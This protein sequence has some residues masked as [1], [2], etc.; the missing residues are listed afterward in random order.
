MITT[1]LIRYFSEEKYADAF[2]KNG[3]VLFRTLSFFKNH[4]DNEIR[5]DQNEGTLV[6]R[7]MSG[8]QVTKV[9]TG[10]VITLPHS[11]ESTVKTDEIF[12]Y[13]MSTELST[14][15]AE[16]FTAVVA[17]EIVDPLKFLARLRNSLSLR[18][19]LR[20]CKLI[21]EAI[22]YY[23]VDEPP[24]VDW[25]LPDRITMRKSKFFGWQKEYRFVVP[26][27]DAFRIENVNIKL[28]MP[29]TKSASNPSSHPPLCL[30]LGNLKSICRVHRF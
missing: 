28:A 3:E 27:G 12:V 25:A 14:T 21:H 7:P 23:E 6:H 29:N 26:I 4:E 13:C 10:E 20:S 11:F 19:R 22:H 8:L 2:L 17:I 18:K 24:V 9:K 16:R 5:G 1:P 30:K 15:I